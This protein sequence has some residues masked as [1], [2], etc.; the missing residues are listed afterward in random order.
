LAEDQESDVLAKWPAVGNCSSSVVV[1]RVV[2]LEAVLLLRYSRYSIR[3][4]LVRWRIRRNLNRSTLGDQS[5]SIL[6]RFSGPRAGGDAGAAF[7]CL[8]LDGRSLFHQLLLLSTIGSHRRSRSWYTVET[9]ASCRKSFEPT[10]NS[11]NR[12]RRLVMIAAIYGR[13]SRTDLMEHAHPTLRS[14]NRP[15]AALDQ[16][17]MPSMR[18][19]EMPPVP[20]TSMTPPDC[21]G[22]ETKLDPLPFRRV[23]SQFV[24]SRQL[25]HMGL[26]PQRDILSRTMS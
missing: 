11:E 3:S 1:L 12:V 20:G 7:V 9:R 14:G 4:A 2:C 15:W 22:H 17:G 8:A 16:R 10:L 13:K 23:A 25:R 6:N 26:T 18:T 24:R 21:L 19:S 5:L